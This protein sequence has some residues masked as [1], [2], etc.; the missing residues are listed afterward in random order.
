MARESFAISTVRIRPGTIR[1]LELPITRLV[2][3]SDVSLSLRVVHGREDVPTV[4]LDA[5]IHGS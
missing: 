5:A 3:G 4:W 2:T 1:N